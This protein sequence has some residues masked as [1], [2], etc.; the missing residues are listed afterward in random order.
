M[1]N[2]GQV[3]SIQLA[4]SRRHSRCVNLNVLSYTGILQCYLNILDK[5]VLKS[6][7]TQ[8]KLTYITVQAFTFNGKNNSCLRWWSQG[9]RR[10]QALT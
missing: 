3:I 2:R 7:K 9:L 10:R 1:Q 6:S 8:V 4:P 5:E